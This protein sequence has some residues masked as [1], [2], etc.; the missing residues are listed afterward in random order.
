MSTYCS[1]LTCHLIPFNLLYYEQIRLKPYDLGQYLLGTI[2]SPI[3]REETAL[4]YLVYQE[5]R[6]IGSLVDNLLLFMGGKCGTKWSCGYVNPI[7]RRQYYRVFPQMEKYDDHYLRVR[8][9]KNM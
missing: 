2:P 7:E 3:Q 5:P 6:D 9:G 4:C 8:Y 1:G